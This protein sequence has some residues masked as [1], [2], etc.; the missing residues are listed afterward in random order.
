MSYGPALILR[1]EEREREGKK[2]K[3][4][5]EKK[6]KKGGKRVEKKDV[7]MEAAGAPLD[8]AHATG[9]Y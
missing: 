6:E 8:S 9:M 3:R 1:T 5:E 7:A 2:R 4:G